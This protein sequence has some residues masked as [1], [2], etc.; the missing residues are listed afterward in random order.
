MP[1]DGISCNPGEKGEVGEAGEA[2]VWRLEGYDAFSN[3]EY[4]LQGTYETESAAEKAAQKRLKEL[5]KS[6]PSANSGG[7][8]GIQDQVSIVHPDGKKQRVFPE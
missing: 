6:Q 5:E 2:D 3:E 8:S 4:S 1:E 7:Q